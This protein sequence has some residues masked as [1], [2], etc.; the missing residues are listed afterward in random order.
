VP[1]KYKELC[2]SRPGGDN[3]EEL[4]SFLTHNRIA[5]ASVEKLIYV[6]FLYPFRSDLLKR[7]LT[8]CHNL[9]DVSIQDSGDVFQ[10]ITNLG[11]LEAASQVQRL[12][13]RGF[14][15]ATVKPALPRMSGLKV[16][17]FQDTDFRAEGAFK[18][19]PLVASITEVHFID[20]KW[21]GETFN[22]QSSMLLD[23]A[24]ELDN[25]RIALRGPARRW[26][27]LRYLSFSTL[28]LE[29]IPKDLALSLMPFTRN[30]T[31]LSV[32]AN[33]IYPPSG[34]NYN[35]HEF[36][37][38]L[39]SLTIKYLHQNDACFIAS[40]HLR[41]RDWF[42]KLSQLPRLSVH[43]EIL[44]KRGE[45]DWDMLNS[46]TG[47]LDGT[48]GEASFGRRRGRVSSR[49]GWRKRVY[50]NTLAMGRPPFETLGMLHIQQI[51]LYT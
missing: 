10:D 46:A 26:Q 11:G 24:P 38:D 19:Y 14:T 49:G 39:R 13:L 3:L 45:L 17:S 16:L 29:N 42:P 12:A 40:T 48:N 25:V 50:R 32:Y 18:N 33:C 8:A 1:Y 31:K 22:Y 51:A 44:Y 36:F 34:Y 4:C 20:C 5:A 37:P 23:M 28:I 35:W 2:L 7:V 47:Q 21:P 30:I 41:N 43:G 27:G 15:S 6:S 9:R